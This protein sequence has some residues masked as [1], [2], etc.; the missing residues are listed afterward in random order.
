MVKSGSV[1]MRDR[2]ALSDKEIAKGFVLT[3]Q[4]MPRSKNIVLDYDE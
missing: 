3:C 4:A 1:E 2:D